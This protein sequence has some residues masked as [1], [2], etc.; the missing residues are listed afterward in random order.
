VVAG[1]GHHGVLSFDPAQEDCA[2]PAG[3][4][5]HQAT[6][7]LSILGTANQANAVTSRR[8][9]FSTRP[10]WSILDCGHPS[11]PNRGSNMMP[12]LSSWLSPWAVIALAFLGLSMVGII[13]NLPTLTLT[14]GTLEALG[15]SR[16]DSA[17]STL[18]PDV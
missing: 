11:G 13:T 15:L 5:S 12:S 10:R 14:L 8:F 17:E 9:V 6:K 18:P 1:I 4:I 7:V 3:S 16:A 2:M